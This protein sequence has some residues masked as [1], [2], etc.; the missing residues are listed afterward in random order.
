[1]VMESLVNPAE[2]EKRPWQMF[3]LGIF[4]ASLAIILSL[5]IFKDYS[6]LVMVFLIVMMS[7]PLIYNTIKLEENKDEQELNESILLKEHSKALGVFMFLFF[8]ITIACTLWY[9]FLPHSYAEPLF[10]VQAETIQQI[11][12]PVDARVTTIDTLGIIFFNNLRVLSI[13][14]LFSFLFG[15]GAMFILTWNATVIA[16]AI[17]AFI[18]IELAKLASLVGAT[19]MS[20]YFM[21]FSQG[22]FK[23]MTHGI[24]EILAYFVAALAG[25]II[26]MAV[27]NHMIFSPKFEKIVFDVSELVIISVSLLFISALIEV[28]VTYPLFA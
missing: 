4:F 16:A 7:F 9:I 15:V 14:V 18:R 6:S 8:G 25:G 2:A 19:S 24:F 28:F 26:S 10:K 27:I 12:K 22:V 17:G 11:N 1:M 5:F 3:F 13:C 21:I 23:Y 20:D